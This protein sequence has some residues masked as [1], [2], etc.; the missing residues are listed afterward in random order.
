M[1]VLKN[2]ANAVLEIV[3]Q[4]ERKFTLILPE[5]CVAGELFDATWELYNSA[6]EILVKHQEALAK[7]H[8]EDN[9]VVTPSPEE[10]K[11]D[12]VNG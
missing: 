4:D 8:E 12:L 11:V 10:V 3:R 1:A 5:N 6:C 2:S 9:K 7:K